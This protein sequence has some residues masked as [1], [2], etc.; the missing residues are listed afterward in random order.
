MNLQKIREVLNSAK[1][2]CRAIAAFDT[3]SYHY[4]DWAA[5]AANRLGAPLFLMF[6]PNF[7]KVMSFREFVGF[8]RLLE[9]KYSVPLITH[10]DHSK[11]IDEI[12][13]AIRAGFDSVMLDY[14]DRPLDENTR[15]TKE[16]VGIAHSAGVA[17]EAE[18]GRVGSGSN[19]A[20]FKNPELYTDAETARR[21]CQET[22]VDMLAVAIG[23]SHGVYVEEPHLDIARLKK[24]TS[25]VDVPL[26]LH[27]TSLIPGSQVTAAV[28]NGICKVN[29]AT[30]MYLAAMTALSRSLQDCS[31]E[32]QG[33]F[34]ADA[35]IKPA[36]DEYFTQKLRLL[37][38]SVK[39][40]G[41]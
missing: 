9:E 22:H 37:N 39:G 21:F 5:E 27:G 38:R 15:V 8:K 6:Y 13:E 1:R 41:A 19:A 31:E 16:V 32:N 20:D 36:M 40:D 14:S 23:N 24:L 10:L 26:V 29:L 2:N 4:M 28:A 11:S 34:F 35:A 25:L 33:P 7:K 12:S 3:V 18:L 30:E 17:V